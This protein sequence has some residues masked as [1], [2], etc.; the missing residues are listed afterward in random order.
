MSK[1]RNT[2]LKIALILAG[3]CAYPIMLASQSKLTL[4]IH[5]RYSLFTVIMCAIGLVLAIASAVE[6]LQNTTSNKEH[7][8]GKRKLNI[9]NSLSV[10]LL[11]V[12]LIVPPQTL[13]SAAADLKQSNPATASYTTRPSRCAVPSK[14]Y[15]ATLNDWKILT[16]ECA[17]PNKY[18][19]QNVDL[20]GF[21]YRPKDKFLQDNTFYVSRFVMS[22][23]AVDAEPVMLLVEKDNWDDQL[24]VDDWIR[25]TGTL[26]YEISGGAQQL[27][28]KPRSIKKIPQPKDPYDYYKDVPTQN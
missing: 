16:S 6:A 27:V 26:S 10:L 9:V 12:A 7:D 11:A 15:K 5:P 13:Q 21:V 14:D 25:V 8:R 19:G 23:C 1:Q 22:C 20:I 17:T 4:Y 2:N 3:F 28:I 24:R 18:T